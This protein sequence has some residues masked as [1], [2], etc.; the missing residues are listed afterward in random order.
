MTNEKN[1]AT[2]EEISLV[3]RCNEIH[4]TPAESA[5]KA[6]TKADY[7]M[8]PLDCYRIRVVQETVNPIVVLLLSSYCIYSSARYSKLA[9]V[10][11]SDALKGPKLRIDMKRLVSV[12]HLGSITI[13]K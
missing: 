13:Q 10:S 3:E 12:G 6:G 9:I 8:H 5:L 2:C 11:G 7:E 1:V 4:P